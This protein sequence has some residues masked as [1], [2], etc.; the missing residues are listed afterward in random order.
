MM[1]RL[2]EDVDDWYVVRE[3]HWLS[4]AGPIFDGLGIDCPLVLEPGLKKD[5][6]SIQSAFLA[7][8][9]N[10]SRTVIICKNQQWQIGDRLMPIILLDHDFHPFVEFVKV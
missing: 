9:A 8:E 1:F 6:L 4:V 10:T 5:L 7:V 2:D 3:I